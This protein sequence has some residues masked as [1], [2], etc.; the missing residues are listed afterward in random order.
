M[1]FNVAMNTAETQTESTRAG[2]VPAPP[3]TVV[4]LSCAAYLAH[5][6]VRTAY[7]WLDRGLLEDVRGPDRVAGVT[8]ANITKITGKSY[9]WVQTSLRPLRAVGEYYHAIGIREK[10]CR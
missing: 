3:E 6:S 2:Q 7:N 9:T 8:L 1:C 4:R 5:V 10:T